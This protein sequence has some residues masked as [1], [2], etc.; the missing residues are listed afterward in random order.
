[1]TTRWSR[2]GLGPR[3]F[4]MLAGVCTVGAVTAW[5]VALW[6]GPRLF[7]RHLIQA[8]LEGHSEAT[9]HAEE[10]FS[11]ASAL[12]LGAAL[13]AA[14]VTA[15][16]ASAWLSRRLSRSLA[17]L[18]DAATAVGTGDY[19][20]RIGAAG[21]GPE[22]D[23]LA[24][25]FTSMAAQLQAATD[26]RERLL[27]DL[28]HELR[29][30]VTNLDATLE[31]V[32]D[33]VIELDA[34]TVSR[35]RDQGRRLTRLAEDL[36]AVT[37]AQ[38]GLLPLH[39]IG[40]EPAA[41]VDRT[42]AAGAA[43]ARERGVDLRGASAADLPLVWVDP[44]R[45]AQVMDNLVANAL[46]HT[47]VG[48][49]IA[50]TAEHTGAGVELAVADSGSGIAPEHLPH[51]FERFYRADAARDRDSGGSGVGL[52]ICMAL[53]RAHGGAIAASSDGPG[54]GATFTVTLPTVPPVVP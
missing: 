51:V 18:T 6:V 2:A 1:M 31:A 49:A 25:S 50:I 34:A 33:G 20:A 5:I 44:E 27:A 40:T 46:V 41:I 45:L 23:A 53:V 3:F 21:L 47:E 32:S 13:A 36:A 10:A 16:V 43:R 29:T 19:S 24:Q 30:P 48:G 14:A 54:K 37:R 26:L 7:H 52:A 15:L 12:A 22:F 42:V 9:M 17:S 11:S 4:A 8:G 39:R 28:A 35:L 38:A